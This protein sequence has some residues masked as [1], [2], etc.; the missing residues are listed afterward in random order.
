MGECKKYSKMGFTL[1]ISFIE[2]SYFAKTILDQWFDQVTS[3]TQ[4][5]DYKV[6]DKGAL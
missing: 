1:V 4:F 5:S 6:I 3:S 2:L